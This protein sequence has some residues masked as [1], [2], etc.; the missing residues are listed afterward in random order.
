MP[1]AANISRTLFMT[2]RHSYMYLAR[3]SYQLPSCCVVAGIVFV[4]Y[5]NLI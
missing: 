5:E 4:I 1:N 3:T 2:L